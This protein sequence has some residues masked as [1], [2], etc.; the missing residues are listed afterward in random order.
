MILF[1]SRQ[2]VSNQAQNQ[3]MAAQQQASVT[4]NQGYYGFQNRSNQGM[5]SMS[6]SN[7]NQS[8][9]SNNQTSFNNNQDRWNRK[10]KASF[11]SNMSS[12][13]GQGKMQRQ[14][15]N[16][17]QPCKWLSV[18]FLPPDVSFS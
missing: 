18:H 8:N 10:R 12:F 7:N 6:F 14:G 17:G 3:P 11:S 16:A 2:S 9:Y 1:C 15:Q 13:D 4:G 5:Q